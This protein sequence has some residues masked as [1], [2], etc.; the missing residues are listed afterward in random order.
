MKAILGNLLAGMCG[1]LLVL[2]V[3]YGISPPSTRDVAECIKTKKVAIVDDTGVSHILLEYTKSDGAS[4]CLKDGGRFV[5]GLRCKDNDED[6]VGLGAMTTAGQHKGDV[7]F[8]LG[9]NHGMA[10]LQLHTER[11]EYIIPR[12]L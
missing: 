9:L 8:A 6:G 3:Q 12:S 1:A 5:L 10:E 4:L 7:V 2:G 11:G